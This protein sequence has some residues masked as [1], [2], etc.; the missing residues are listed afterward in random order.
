MVDALVEQRARIGLLGARPCARSA[1]RFSRSASVNLLISRFN[2]TVACR[3]ARARLDRRIGSPAF[4][5]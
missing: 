3:Y 4:A 5:I 2:S 1:T